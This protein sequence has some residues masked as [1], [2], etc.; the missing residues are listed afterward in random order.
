MEKLEHE[1]LKKE[2]PSTFQVDVSSSSTSTSRGRCKLLG[3]KAGARVN[4][5]ASSLLI[6]PIFSLAIFEAWKVLEIT[7][8]SHTK[9]RT[10]QHHRISTLL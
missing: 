7:L 3:A 6:V 8:T 9:K 2:L 1:N 5:A 10:S 4:G